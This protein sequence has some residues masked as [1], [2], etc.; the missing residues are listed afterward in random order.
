VDERPDEGHQQHERQRQRVEQQA[1]VQPERPRGHPAEQVLADRALLGRPALHGE[2]QDRRDDEGR[3]RRHGAH[4]VA[5]AVGAAPA[6]QQHRG[7]EQRQA[8]EQPGQGEHPGGR[9]GV[10]RPLGTDYRWSRH[11]RIDS[12]RFRA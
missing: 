9:R 2:E 7:A 1:G 6:E 12:V 11:L 5:D 10:Q 4:Q 8:H 3:P